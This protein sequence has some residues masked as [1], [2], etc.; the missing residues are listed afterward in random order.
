MDGPRGT[1]HSA[2]DGPG[3]PSAVAMDGPGGGGGGGGE[4]II[5]GEGHP[6]SD[7]PTPPPLNWHQV[8]NLCKSCLDLLV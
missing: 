1:V 3:G 8:M 7:R 5:G 6:L 4:P 2:T